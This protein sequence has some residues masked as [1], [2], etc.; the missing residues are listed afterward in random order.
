LTINCC[1]IYLPLYQCHFSRSLVADTPINADSHDPIRRQTRRNV[2]SWVKMLKEVDHE[3]L[4]LL[5]AG[6]THVQIAERLNCNKKTIQRKVARWCEVL[7][8]PDRSGL[9]AAYLVH[10]PQQ[11]SETLPAVLRTTLQSNDVIVML[12]DASEAKHAEYQKIYA[13]QATV[14]RF[15][16]PTIEDCTELSQTPRS[17]KKSP[18]LALLN[19]LLWRDVAENYRELRT[20]ANLLK[21]RAIDYQ[22]M[23]RLLFG[24]EAD[25]AIDTDLLVSRIESDSKIWLIATLTA[26]AL[27][28]SMPPMTNIESD[29]LSDNGFAQRARWKRELQFTLD[30]SEGLYSRYAGIHFWTIA[31][32]S[33]LAQRRLVQN[34]DAIRVATANPLCPIIGLLV[35]VFATSNDFN[36]GEATYSGSA[37]PW[38]IQL[39]AIRREFLNSHKIDIQSLMSLT[40]RD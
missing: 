24:R 3:I 22:L 9:V 11:S 15:K 33:L 21:S 1:L 2:F 4:S 20:N 29:Y 19:P 13:A 34:V 12:N 23:D 38:L 25:E 6:T 5:C 14:Q 37:V 18:D 7:K 35:H 17:R 10:F 40:R 27:D 39:I 32:P 28:V 26:R 36:D 16:I 30:L 31:Y 8:L